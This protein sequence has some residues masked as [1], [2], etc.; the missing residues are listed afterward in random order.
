MRNHYKHGLLA[1]VVDLLL[2]LQYSIIRDHHRSTLCSASGSSLIVAKKQQ[3][4][5][6]EEEARHLDI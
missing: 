6:A 4:Q 3:R 1:I 2:D 5:E